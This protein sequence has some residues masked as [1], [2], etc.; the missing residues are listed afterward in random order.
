MSETKNSIS[1][2]NRLGRFLLILVCILTAGLIITYSYINT[3]SFRE[4]VK[5][6]FITELENLMGKKIKIDSADT[7]S[8]RNLRFS[9]LEI[10]EKNGDDTEVFLQAK[11]LEIKFALFFPFWQGKTWQLDIKDIAFTDLSVSFTRNRAGEF[12]LLKK[13]GIDF[14]FLN[15]NIKIERVSF[16]NSSL[17]YHDEIVYHYELDALT[18]KA[19][20]VSGYFDFSTWPETTFALQGRDDRDDALL[21][22]SGFFFTQKREYSLDFHLRNADLTH[23]KYYL[24]A[25]EQLN[26]SRGK[27]DLDLN[28]SISPES[29]NNELDWQ[30]KAV[31]YEGDAQPFFLNEIPFRKINGEVNFIKPEITLSGLNGL[32]E[33][34]PF[35]L[36]GLLLTQPELYFDL[37]ITTGPVNAAL[38][39][40]DLSLF[41]GEYKDF[42][43]Q[44][45]VDLSVNVQG[46]PGAFDIQG[47]VTTPEMMVENLTLPNITAHFLL[48]QEELIINSLKSESSEG[49]V[50]VAGKLDWTGDSP[51]YHFEI[52]TSRL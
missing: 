13:L 20:N 40:D 46:F 7:I 51:F 26:V 49:S 31:F 27:F 48:K 30:G 29:V 52:E 18:T 34:R 38:L 45:E 9:N 2:K 44:G 1:K 15:E 11:K 14:A 33:E 22:F 24:E 21:S 50:S 41:M 25:A 32:Y 16:K 43:I 35:Q 8:F 47:T 19:K 36:E 17:V 37:N 4:H 39:K 10:L 23:F 42:S 5:S 3:S 28:L 6:L 12:D